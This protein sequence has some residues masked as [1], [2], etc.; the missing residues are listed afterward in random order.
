VLSHPANRGD[1]ASF[2]QRT[3]FSRALH[4]RR[5]SERDVDA[6]A[7]DVLTQL[8]EELNEGFVGRV[9]CGRSLAIEGIE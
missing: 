5:Q 9:F 3:V 6:H 1:G 2:W 8:L 7:L 4:A